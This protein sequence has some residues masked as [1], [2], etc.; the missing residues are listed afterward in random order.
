MA[1]F[2]A[3]TMSY[4]LLTIAKEH[5]I[6][7]THQQSRGELLSFLLENTR[8]TNKKKYDG[9]GDCG[10]DGGGGGNDRGLVPVDEVASGGS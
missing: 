8:E 10:G 7:N 2:P 1:T 6:H 3:A 5:L 9:S 4:N